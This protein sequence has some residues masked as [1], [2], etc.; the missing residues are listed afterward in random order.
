MHI[1]LPESKNGHLKPT[2]GLQ[3]AH[4]RFYRIQKDAMSWCHI[5]NALVLS[6]CTPHN[7]LSCSRED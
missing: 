7:V 2:C 5:Y 6:S 3:L 4:V 1:L